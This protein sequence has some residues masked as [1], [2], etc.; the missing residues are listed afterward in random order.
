MRGQREDGEGAEAEQREDHL[1]ELG[2]VRELHD[3]PVAADDAARVESGGEPGGAAVQL[4]V[5]PVSYTHL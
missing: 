1:E 5:G 2:D 4:G 3:D